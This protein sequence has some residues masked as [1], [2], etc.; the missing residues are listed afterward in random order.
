MSYDEYKCKNIYNLM[1]E[2]S[3]E[4]FDNLALILSK[5]DSD[6]YLKHS[7][8]FWATFALLNFGEDGV[9]K[10]IEILSNSSSTIISNK[11]ITVLWNLSNNLTYESRDFVKCEYF[12]KIEI[13]EELHLYIKE[14]FFD[15]ILKTHEDPE[16]FFQLINFITTEVITTISNKEKFISFHKDFFSIIS[17]SSIN[18]SPKIINDFEI[19]I[20]SELREEEY[21]NYLKKF[22]V[23][24]DP[25]SMRIIDKQK[26]GNELITDFII[27]TLKGEYILVEIEKPQDKIFT[28]NDDFSSSFYHA[29]GQVLDFIEWVENNI[30]YAQTLL[31]NIS[32]PKG[33]LI[34][35]RSTQLND[36][37]KNKLKRFNRNS[38][39]I[40]VL[41]YDDIV[42]TSKSLYN[43]IRKK[44]EIKS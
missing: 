30:S 41:T 24:I 33:I 37:R 16:S 44:I 22:P 17:D 14:K 29:F 15:F 40:K 26:L 32:S 19:K 11:I 2:N 31:P 12:N 34:I 5:K 18:I 43:N 9:D 35:G 23:L 13:S 7:L 36:K 27:E 42:Q 4:S 38:N 3:Q 28:L 20:N 8:P 6:L 1:I 25:L 21:Q 10:I 39:S